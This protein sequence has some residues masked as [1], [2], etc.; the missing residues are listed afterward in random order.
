MMVTVAVM[1]VTVTVIVIVIVRMS[2]GGFLCRRR[3]GG[4]GAAQANF[5]QNRAVLVL[6]TVLMI[7][8]IAWCGRQMPRSRSP[9]MIHDPVFPL[10]G[11]FVKDWDPW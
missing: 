2:R 1:M 8:V 3:F 10:P 5:G 9:F 7:V 4:R 11:S 6:M